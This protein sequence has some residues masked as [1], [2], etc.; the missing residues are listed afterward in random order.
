MSEHHVRKLLW[1]AERRL[2]QAWCRGE[3]R[4]VLFLYML[5]FVLYLWLIL[6]LISSYSATA[7]R[8]CLSLKSSW[9]GASP[10]LYAGAKSGMHAEA[11]GRYLPRSTDHTDAFL[12]QRTQL[13]HKHSQYRP[14][15]D[16]MRLS[17]RQRSILRNVD[18]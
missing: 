10:M 18:V 15:G 8:N 9:T 5:P 16:H 11:H 4:Q 7:E 13:W 14:P 12:S 2:F 3:L 1:P 17:S 6:V